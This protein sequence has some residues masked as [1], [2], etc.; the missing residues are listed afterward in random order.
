MIIQGINVANV[1]IYLINEVA[2]TMEYNWSND[3]NHKD[4]KGYYENVHEEMKK[5]DF[6]KLTEEELKFLGF[7]KFSQNDENYL[8]PLWLLK[9]LPDGTKL[10]SIMGEIVEV[11][12]DYI[13][14]DVRGGCT[15]YSLIQNR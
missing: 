2:C 6:N 1:M 9:V 11:G 14:N 15:A 3:F 13:N 8:V 10:Q 12:K 5:I 7:R 4:L